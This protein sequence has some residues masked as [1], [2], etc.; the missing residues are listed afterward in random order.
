MK[1]LSFVNLSAAIRRLRSRIGTWMLIPV[2]AV[3]SSPVMAALPV[4]PTPGT[5]MNGNAVAQGD[6]L[7]ALS[8]WIKAGLAIFGVAIAGYA[9]I[10]VASG[11]L[12]KWKLYSSGR[13][14][15]GDLKEY[16]I[17]AAV[18][19]VFIVMMVT[20]AYSTIGV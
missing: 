4:M 1:S 10:S 2:V 17:L 18:L 7:A 6:W 19:V 11:A 3:L 16:I 8:A 12:G 14:E 5:D 9:F 13:A 20:Y 15:L